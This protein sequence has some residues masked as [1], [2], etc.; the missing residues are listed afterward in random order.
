MRGARVHTEVTEAGPFERTLTVHLDELEF[1]KAKDQAARKL[2]R[3]IKVK[4]FRPGRAP[5][6]IIE[7]M[8][9]ADRLRTEAIEE[10]L[11]EVVSDALVEEGLAP[12]TTPAVEDIRDGDDGGVSID[13]RITLWPSIDTVPSYEGREVTVDL[14][15]VDEAEVDEQIDRFRNQYADLEEVA[16]P[17]DTGDYVMVNITALDGDDLIEEVSASDLLYEVGSGSFI[18]GLDE[19][20]LGSS[21]G[22]IREGPGSLPEGFSEEVSGDVTLRTL[23][24]EVRGKKLPEVTD[25]WVSDVSEFE[26]VAELRDRIS[27][28]MQAMKAS[29]AAGVFQEQLINELAG[30]L[31]I[32]LPAGLI[33]AEV[34]AS[35]HNLMHSLEAQGLDLNNY[36][37]VTGQEPDT[38]LEDLKQRAEQS[39][40]TR[41]LLEAVASDAELEV[42][43][44]DIDAAVAE[45]SA[46]SD[47]NPDEVREALVESGQIEALAGDILRRKA[48][49]L[50]L[51]EA[52]AVDEDGN[53]VDL[54]PPALD[55]EDEAADD[56]DDVADAGANQTDGA[57]NTEPAAVATEDAGSGTEHAE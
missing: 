29:N 3:E 30:E 36:L 26:S 6:T 11:P 27:T 46:Q 47:R 8:V 51:T 21:A 57:S 54:T 16:R 48:L 55:I 35:L 28:N 42:E 44:A 49:D 37:E 34:E 20:L 22:E 19:V 50:V 24:K 18:A 5:R 56:E 23:V 52:T 14:P 41:V 10:A 1:D 12:V 13:V 40:R 7:S 38:F 25:E 33:D 45:L 4:G 2:S 31:D 43:A 17:A 32:E 15:S 53:P 9:G 39:L